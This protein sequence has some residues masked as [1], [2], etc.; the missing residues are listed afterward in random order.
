MPWEKG[1]TSVASGIGG[2]IRNTLEKDIGLVVQGVG[3][4]MSPPMF[5]QSGEL[6]KY[7]TLPLQIPRLKH[8]SSYED[9]DDGIESGSPNTPKSLY[10]KV[11]ETPA[12]MIRHYENPMD[13][14]V[15]GK[16][17]LL[18][19]DD[20]G[21]WNWNPQESRQFTRALIY[22]CIVDDMNKNKEAYKYDVNRFSVVE[23]KDDDN[24]I[25]TTWFA[26]ERSKGAL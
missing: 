19:K 5:G 4:I 18:Y 23:E 6:I 15:N 14:E 21:K 13:V 10:K 11:K 8:N 1:L 24:M 12:D 25:L 20:E 2:S 26:F 9:H 16:F 22:K 17:L 7:Y 3:R